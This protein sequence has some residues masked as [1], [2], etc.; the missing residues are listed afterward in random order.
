VQLNRLKES[1]N[2]GL[3]Q[4]SNYSPAIALITGGGSQADCRILSPA[5]ATKRLPRIEGGKHWT[6]NVI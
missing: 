1:A 6:L 4:V 3:A 2:L 5:G